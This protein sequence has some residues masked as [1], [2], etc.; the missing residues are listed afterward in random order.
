MRL[1]WSQRSRRDLIAIGE[2]IGADSRAAASRWIAKIVARARQ[3]AR[4]PGSG[5]SVLEF[6]R[7]DVREVLLGSYRLVYRVLPGKIHILTVFEGHKQLRLDPE[8][9]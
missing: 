8:E 7:E 2:F 5:R 9:T 4:N 1:Q 3:A 6:A